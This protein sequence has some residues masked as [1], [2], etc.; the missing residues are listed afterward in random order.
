MSRHGSNPQLLQSGSV[1][2]REVRDVLY[3]LQG[4]YINARRRSI[5]DEIDEDD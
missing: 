5:F 1:T 2:N 3:A 4:N